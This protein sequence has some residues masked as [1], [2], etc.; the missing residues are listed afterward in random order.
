MGA[1]KI[2][3][4]ALMS[5]VV[6]IASSKVCA[7]IN[8]HAPVNRCKEEYAWAVA[9]S[10]ISLVLCAGLLIVWKLGKIQQPTLP[11]AH[12][13]QILAV[14]LLIWW[15]AGAGVLTFERPFRAPGNGYFGAWA[16]F[17]GSV[18]IAADAIPQ[19]Q[20]VTSAL[21]QSGPQLMYVLFASIILAA[22]AF[23]DCCN[24]SGY[25][26]WA[27][28]LSI[29]SALMCL[30]AIFLA[31]K[32]AP[33]AKP[34][35]GLLFAMWLSG[36]ITIT[37]FG[38]YRGVGN[39][40]FALCAATVFSCIIASQQFG[41]LA[42]AES[43]A[44]DMVQKGMS[45]WG[46]PV[47]MG[48]VLLMS[49]ALLISSAK[50]CSDINKY[51]PNNRCTDEYAWGIACAVVSLVFCG[52]LLL[53]WK[54]G[55]I[56]TPAIPGAK[57]ELI[58]AVFLLLWWAAGAAVLTFDNPFRFPGNGYFSTWCAFF[59]C[60]SMAASVVPQLQGAASTLAQSGA[61]LMYLLFAG[62]VLLIQASID[63]CWKG[64]HVF[65][66]ILGCVTILA[67]LVG[68]FAP[69]ALASAAKPFAIIMFLL[70]LSGWF[71]MTFFDPY[72]HVGNGYFAVSA[73]A[74]FSGLIAAEQMGLKERVV[75]FASDAKQQVLLEHPL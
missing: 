68:I 61:E 7:D 15:G 3:L 1:A 60:V 50:L 22:Q 29:V 40:Y 75:N 71:V 30:V 74:V 59:V 37:F 52:V 48:I 28:I 24:H 16:A 10:V 66:I 13:E 38:P 64:Y 46:M 35:S 33:F 53:L 9:C 34:F 73:G 14:F 44:G 72:R 69:G 19:L 42:A 63:C 39:A 58:T 2:A 12:G 4:V 31:D 41:M 54:I 26:V 5:L 55:H 8:R 49:L 18:S 51:Y 57:G 43:A 45:E 67:C 23:R 21:G 70:W 6:L 36:W 20:N 65:A 27:I 62:V 47:K 32:L 56:G 17:F 11:G 25:V